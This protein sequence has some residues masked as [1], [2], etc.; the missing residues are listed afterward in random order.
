MLK[1]NKKY[2]LPEAKTESIRVLKFNASTLLEVVVAMVLIMVVF[3]IGL[4]SYM[5]IMK[6]SYNF[7]KLRASQETERIATATKKEKTFVD[8]AYETETVSYYKSI[9]KY[10]GQSNLIL[11]EVEAVDRSNQQ[12]ALRRELILLDDE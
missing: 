5:N 3:G 4:M 6:S 9:K 2:Q 7:Q 8:Q 11:L 12:L 10:E 1:F